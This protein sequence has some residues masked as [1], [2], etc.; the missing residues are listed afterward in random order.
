MRGCPIITSTLIYGLSFL[1]CSPV[2]LARTPRNYY[3]NTNAN[4]E[5]VPTIGLQSAWHTTCNLNSIR[6]VFWKLVMVARFQ[7]YNA[8]RRPDDT[9]AHEADGWSS[10]P[11]WSIDVGDGPIVATAV[12]SGHELR[13]EVAEWMAIEDLQRLRE[14]DPLTDIWTSVGDSSIRVYRSRFEV[15]LNRPRDKA[16]AQNPDDSWGLTVWRERPPAT[17]IERSLA[18]YDSFYDDVDALLD[19]LL[20]RWNRILVL[21]LHSYNH[22]RNGPN[23]PGASQL[24]NPEVNI[25]TGTMD[26]ERWMPLVDTFIAELRSQNIRGRPLDVREN[27]KFKGGYFPLSLHS[28]YPDNVCVLSIE[29]KKIFMDEWKATASIAAVEALRIALRDAANAIRPHL[30]DQKGLKRD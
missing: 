18:E 1:A 19:F 24:C 9:D 17:V 30:V 6:E 16:I 23:Q 29:F 14:E 22:C 10:M 4:A 28:R 3:Q 25:G 12:H 8:V 2:I 21:D 13:P 5:G 7:N 20:G 11:P 26:R 27:V 15:D